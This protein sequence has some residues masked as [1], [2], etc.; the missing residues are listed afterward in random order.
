MKST[1]AFMPLPLHRLDG[2]EVQI[3]TTEV[4]F[5]RATRIGGKECTII[6]LLSGMD[7]VVS[8]AVSDVLKTLKINWSLPV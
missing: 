6:G 8:E 5:V 4:A 2:R 3:G 1:E 7:V